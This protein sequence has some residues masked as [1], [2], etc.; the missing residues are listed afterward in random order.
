M[1]PF[2]RVA[3]VTSEQDG[4]VLR[5]ELGEGRPAAFT[6]HNFLS[7]ESG[8]G[9]H[10][11]FCASSQQLS[12]RLCTRREADRKRRSGAQVCVSARRWTRFVPHR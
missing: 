4:G 2:A 8:A 10:A 1:A 6:Q 9:V 5:E 3:C 11:V 12:T 7:R